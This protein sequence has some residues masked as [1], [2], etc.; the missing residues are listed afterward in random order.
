MTPFSG[1]GGEG[2][3]GD[4]GGPKKGVRGGQKGGVRKTGFWGSLEGNALKIGVNPTPGQPPQRDFSGKTG[5][6]CL[7]PPQNPQ[8]GVE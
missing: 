8:T 5:Q 3:S 4:P 2:G 7:G 1:G 6:N